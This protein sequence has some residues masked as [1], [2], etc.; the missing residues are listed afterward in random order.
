MLFSSGRGGL[1]ETLTEILLSPYCDSREIR[2]TPLAWQTW[3]AK[4]QEDAS[5]RG[6]LALEEAGEI[7]DNGVSVAV[8]SVEGSLG[9][10]SSAQE[11]AIRGGH[12]VGTGL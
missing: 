12:V 10:L 9:T 8:S 2:G 11:G 3:N 5:M 1:T 6:R 4:Q 7:L